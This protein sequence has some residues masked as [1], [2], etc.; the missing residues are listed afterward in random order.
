[1]KDRSSVRSVAAE[2]DAASAALAQQNKRVRRI[3]RS[4]RVRRVGGDLVTDFV[5]RL[6]SAKTKRA[7]KDIEEMS[8][9]GDHLL[10]ATSF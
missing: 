10:R 3:F 5:P 9:N 4:P 7:L 2:I 1:M 6:L 8:A